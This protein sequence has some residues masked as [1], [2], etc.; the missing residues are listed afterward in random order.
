LEVHLGISERWT[1]QSPGYQTTLKY[2]NQ[3]QFQLAVDKLEGL[4]VQRLF[5]L[6]KANASETGYKLRTHINKAIKSR[7]KACQRALR[8]YNLA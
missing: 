4:V 5:E 8:A 3:R 6:T 1:S 2:M 7:S